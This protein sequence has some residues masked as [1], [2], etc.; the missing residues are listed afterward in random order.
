MT[1]KTDKF[2]S[3]AYMSAV[4]GKKTPIFA[5]YFSNYT[6]LNK[7][8]TAFKKLSSI[9]IKLDICLC[10]NKGADSCAVSDQPNCFPYMDSTISP[11]VKSKI[12]S[13]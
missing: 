5:T 7:T 13:F 3:K 11:L 2:T 10:Q 8:F 12:S 4:Q 1:D 9:D 6:F